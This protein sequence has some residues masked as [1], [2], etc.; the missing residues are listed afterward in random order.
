MPSISAHYKDISY[1]HIKRRIFTKSFYI[2]HSTQRN[3]FCIYGR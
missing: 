2:R 1:W 3:I